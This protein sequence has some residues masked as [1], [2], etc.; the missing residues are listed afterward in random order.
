M[1][2]S[3]AV[4]PRAL[5]ATDLDGTL[6]GADGQLSARTTRAL[7]EAAEGPVEVVVVTGRPPMFLRSLLAGARVGG[8]ALCA[9]GAIV[10]GLATLDVLQAHAMPPATVR[11]ILDHAA[12]AS[13]PTQVRVM[14]WRSPKESQRLMGAGGSAF[15]AQVN[16]ALGAGWLPY[17]VLVAS[18][19]ADT[20]PAAYLAHMQAELGAAA[21][22]THSMPGHAVVEIGPD[23][24]DK[25]TAL[26]ALAAARGIPRSD[27]IIEVGET[28]RVLRRVTTDRTEV[29]DTRD[30]SWVR[31]DAGPEESVAC[32]LAL[33]AKADID[34]RENERIRAQ[35]ALDECERR[36]AA[37]RARS[38]RLNAILRECGSDR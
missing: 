4:P 15:T 3:G 18:P 14:L 11:T 30:P 16:A 34:A 33:R 13:A 32:V 29:L 36:L 6:L 38:E 5:L 28:V 17:K 19:D 9:N 23:G 25:G 35:R 31:A 22:V 7:A 8:E 1:A 26:R 24:G 27:V 12:A 10:V 20:D 2:P 37:A 21:T